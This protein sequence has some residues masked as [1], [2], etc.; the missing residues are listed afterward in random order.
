MTSAMV[1]KRTTPSGSMI[2]V[3]GTLD[4]PNATAIEPLLSST[5]GQS[6]PSLAKNDSTAL[7]SSAQAIV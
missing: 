2:H 1:R 6:P 5:T 7:R 3:S 4:T